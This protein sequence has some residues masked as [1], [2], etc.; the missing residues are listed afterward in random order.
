[1]VSA[2][3]TGINRAF[4]YVDP[5]AVEPLVERVS[6]ALFAIAHS[7]NLG[8]ALQALALL[9]QLLSARAAVS[10][11][12]YRALYAVLLHPG[13]PRGRDRTTRARDTAPLRECIMRQK[14]RV[15]VGRALD[16]TLVSRVHS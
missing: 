3:L 12:F 9:L 7:P 8:G 10:D 4:P 15:G 14:S 1:M 11:R 6:P 16:A 5:D 2:L 13:A